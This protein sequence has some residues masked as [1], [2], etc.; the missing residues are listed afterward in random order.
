MSLIIV[1]KVP[2]A[3]L[4]ALLMTHPAVMDAAVVGLPDDNAG[5]LPL[6][7]V[8]VRPGAKVTPKDIQ[9]YV[10]GILKIFFLI[11]LFRLSFRIY[12]YL[13][14]DKVS[15]PKQLRGGVRFIE[16]IP[17]NPTGKILRRVLKKRAIETKSKL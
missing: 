12:Y 13:F 11:F 2:P 4:E 9:D 3:E 16:S 5:E 8:V 6:G 10:K 15:P 7:Y 14:P 17:R 1:F